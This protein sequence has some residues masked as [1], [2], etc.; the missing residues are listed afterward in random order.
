MATW[1][2]LE[3]IDS[4]VRA[5][6]RPEL[7]FDPDA[8]R[9]FLDVY[10]NGRSAIR[11]M[12]TEDGRKVLVSDLSRGEELFLR[13]RLTDSRSIARQPSLAGSVT[14]HLLD[15]ADLDVVLHLINM[16]LEGT[17]VTASAERSGSWDQFIHWSAR[18]F[19]SA[20]FD[21]NERDYKLTI[22]A[23]LERAR[24]ALLDDSPDWM[25]QLKRGFQSPNN[26][27]NWRM[28]SVFL[29][30]CEQNPD[31]AK[32][33]LRLIWEPLEPRRIRAFLR[34]VPGSVVSGT[35]G[36]LSLA[37]FLQMALDV[38]EWTMYRS[39][40]LSSGYSL[41]GFDPPADNN[42]EQAVYDHAVLFLDRLMDEAA[43]RGLELRD[44]LDAQ[45]VLW[46]VTS[47]DTS[48]PP[49]STWPVEDQRWFHQFR[50]DPIPQA[51]SPTR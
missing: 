20:E 41:T 5:V 9:M 11:W 21:T 22:G 51:D 29:K 42:D 1:S 15:V 24:T 37:S 3:H 43:G 6:N 50:G 25:K 4:W 33:A 26:L 46:C 17:P 8:G 2:T 12:R 49:G 35:G 7:T 27:T 23:N 40:P 38:R 28:H 34:M 16:R 44:R 10:L 19:E 48:F 36:R 45:S 30:W 14:L 47:W 18:F 32:A 31:S 39:S 13:Q